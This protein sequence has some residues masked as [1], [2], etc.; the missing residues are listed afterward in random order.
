[1]RLSLLDLSIIGPTETAR[2]SLEGSVRLA[3]AAE[4]GGLHRIWFAEHHNMREVASSA[5]AVLVGH[6]AGATERIRVGAGGIMLPNHSP[7]TVAEQF[8]TLETLYPGRIDLGLGR[9]PGGDR[10][11]LYA[12]RRDETSSDRFPSDV[13]ELQ[14]YLNEEFDA[15][16]VN[17]VPGWGTRV[18]LYILGSS[19]FGAD[20]AAKLGLPY[21]FASH[22]APGAL[23]DALAHYRSTFRP[24]AELAEPYT[25]VG[26]NVF[27]AD[28]PEDAERIRQ[29]VTRQRVK[30]FLPPGRNYTDQEIDQILA[31][32]EGTKVAE[33][34]SVS[35]V[36]TGPEVKR[37]LEAIKQATGTDEIIATFN[38]TTVAERVRAVEITA[39]SGVVSET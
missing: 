5:T 30:R 33:M 39:A 29:Q 34:L 23:Q 19:L 37:G 36:G 21:A 32:P 14:R 3:R 22:F 18:P 1:M 38:G 27:A 17:A 31:S 20:L 2:E 16:G 9:A 11:T 35:A 28:T 13:V 7:L 15:Q 4:A 6:I 8:G 10:R 24:S 25:I 26:A 12:L